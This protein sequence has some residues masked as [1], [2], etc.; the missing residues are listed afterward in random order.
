[1]SKSPSPP[2]STAHTKTYAYLRRVWPPIRAQIEAIVPIDGKHEYLGDVAITHGTRAMN[3]IAR[4]N[5][6]ASF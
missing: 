4:P 3:D 1:M 2:S 6:Q 5:P